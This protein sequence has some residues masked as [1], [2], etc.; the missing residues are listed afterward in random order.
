MPLVPLG[1]WK[2]DVSDFQ[3]STT[4]NV[5]NVVPRADGYGPF[6]S[7]LSISESLGEPCRGAIEAV[8]TDGS[9]VIFAATATDLHVLD[10][11]SLSWV[12]VSKGGTS[13]TAVSPTDQWQFRQFNNLV[14][15]VQ[16]NT[17]PQV[18]D[19]VSSS[20]FA[21][22][23]GNP[24]QA[25]YIDIVGRFVVLTGLPAA[26]NRVQW[27]GL[28]DV[29]GPDSWTP[30]INSSDFQDFPDGGKTRGVAGGESGGVV[31]QDTAIRRMTY[32]P[33]SPVIFQ[34]ERIAQDLGIYAA[35][36]LIRA[37]ERVF[38]YSTKGFYRVDPGSYPAPIGRERVDRTFFADLDKDN[39]QLF[40]GAAD[41]RN[42]RV[43]WAYKS[44][45]G[46]AK[47][48]DKL[49]CYDWALDRFT[50][51]TISGEYLYTI[52]Q[53]GI[54]LENLDALTTS[55]DALTTSL[56]YFSIA[57]PPELGVIT[58]DHKIGFF[59][60]QTLEATVE[61]GEQGTDGRRI[62]VRGFRP[63]TDAPVVYGSVSK[64][65]NQ[66][67]APTYSSEGSLNGIGRCDV[68]ASTRY[69][70]AKCRIPAGT[71]WSFI[72]GVEPDFVYQ[73]MK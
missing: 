51:L 35:G 59:R 4:R 54:T 14:I 47:Q 66:R 65:E 5:L 33:G 41:P 73:G 36:S 2:P 68:L 26:P 25:S 27:S 40:I 42:T 32:V 24:P 45:N 70:R 72:A 63:I 6:P 15:A 46:S 13:Y 1:E 16:A 39:L 58:T 69:S 62:K 48:F 53:P 21:D 57:A 71:H 20:E 17:V 50:P 7:L 44:I 23:D 31:L 38:F 19:I 8:K 30:G 49:L 28:N 29:N 64:R 22:L 11:T 67:D 43:F 52:G 37:G 55:L 18:Y 61:T 60:G 34:I 12:N 9:F 56:D 10:N 3:G